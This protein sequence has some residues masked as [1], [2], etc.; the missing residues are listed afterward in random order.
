MAGELEFPLHKPGKTAN[1]IL[2][3]LLCILCVTVPAAIWLLTRLGKMK[4]IV[5]SDG[6]EAIGPFMT[7]EVK[8][9][10]V[11]RFGILRVPMVAR[12]LGGIVAAMKLN[13]MNEGVNLVFKLKSGKEVKFIGNQFDNHDGLVEAVTARV[14]VPR[15]EIKMGI[16][17]WKWP[18]KT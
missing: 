11:E 4:V 8:F 9:D 10:D 7:D 5:R 18:E 13:N 2:A 16:L 17:S 14:R 1:I 3:V 6:L 12:G 15:E